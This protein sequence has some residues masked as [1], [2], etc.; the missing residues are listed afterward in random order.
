M[1]RSIGLIAV[2]RPLVAENVF[3][4]FFWSGFDVRNVR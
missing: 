4:I 2:E 3:I 1:S